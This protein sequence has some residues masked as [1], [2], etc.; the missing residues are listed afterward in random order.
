M[1]NTQYIKQLT[2]H[3][4]LN[5]INHSGVAQYVAKYSIT[6][7]E[8][9]PCFSENNELLCICVLFTSKYEKYNSAC[10]FDDFNFNLTEVPNVNKEWVEFMQKKFGKEYTIAY[11][12]SENNKTK[13][14][15]EKNKEQTK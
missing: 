4:A 6:K 11:K 3:E 10:F 8:F 15:I 5:F 13:Q 12:D 14:H 9:K 7:I 1:N 2:A